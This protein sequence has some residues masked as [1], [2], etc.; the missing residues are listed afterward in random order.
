MWLEVIGVK[1]FDCL[2]DA[3][4][5]PLAAPQGELG[6]HDVANAFMSEVETF[7]DTGENAPTNEFFDTFCGHVL[8]KARG[9]V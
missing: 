5:K 1:P 2:C 8:L 4:M 7:S 9:P 3:V 6:V